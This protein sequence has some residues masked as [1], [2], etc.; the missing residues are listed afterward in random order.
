MCVIL[1]NDRAFE[2]F[3]DRRPPAGAKFFKWIDS[4]GGRLIAGGKLLKELARTE[5]FRKWWQQA[6][7]AGRATLVDN[8]AVHLETTRLVEQMAC[9]SNDAHVVALAIVG[10]ARLLYTNDTKLKRDFANRQLIDDPPGKV[11]STRVSGNFN[12]RKRALLA[13]SSCTLAEHG[14]RC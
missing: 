6:V 11:Y 8:D 5:D 3:G 2:V 4:G 14:S 12:P 13:T 1:D 7:L 10:R 9:Q